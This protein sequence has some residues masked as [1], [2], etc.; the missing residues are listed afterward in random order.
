M[1]CSSIC[2]AGAAINLFFFFG[3]GGFSCFWT[4]VATCYTVLYV[5]SIFKNVFYTTSVALFSFD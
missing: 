3:G 5:Q 4:F 1:Y 2:Y